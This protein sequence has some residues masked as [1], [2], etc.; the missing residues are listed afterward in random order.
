MNNDHLEVANRGLSS[1]RS[2]QS[3]SSHEQDV[4]EAYA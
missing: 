4:R 2:A 3:K 1:I